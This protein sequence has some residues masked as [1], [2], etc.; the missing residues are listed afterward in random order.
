MSTPKSLNLF[1]TL[2]TLITEE[3]ST[4]KSH[5]THIN[6]SRIFG[7][8]ARISSHSDQE[9]LIKKTVSAIYSKRPFIQSRKDILMKITRKARTYHFVAQ[10]FAKKVLHNVAKRLPI[11]SQWYTKHFPAVRL[12]HAMSPLE[13]GLNFSSEILVAIFVIVIAGL[14]IV[15]FNP[16]S[17]TYNHQ[18]KSLAANLLA[19]HTG[20]NSALAAKHNTVSTSIASSGGFISKA[21]ADDNS[22]GSVL[23]ATDVA[24]SEVSEDGIEDNGITKANPDSVQKLVS[25]QVQ[26]YETKPFDTVYT[27]AAQF[28]VTPKT[29]RE[30]NGLP[31]NALKAGWFIVVPPVDGIV[32]EVNNPDLSLDDIASKYRAD[33]DK[34]VSYNGLEGPDSEIA[35]GDYLVIPGGVLPEAPKP[36]AEPATGTTSKVAKGS[37]PS[38]PKANFKGSNKFARGQCTDYAAQHAKVYWRGNANMWATNARKA[39]ATVNMTPS[40]GAIIQTSESRYGHVGVIESVSGNQV[41]FGEWNYAGPY[42]YTRRTLSINDPKVKAIIHP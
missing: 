2:G 23:G 26:I 42:K 30:T 40:V 19:N 14:N 22:V 7:G 32:L 8:I 10:Y 28:K 29:I 20:L 38:I 31:N 24:E 21:F 1:M 13:Y 27:V 41:T 39:G 6:L 12:N 35:M 17:S 9:I 25:R 4:R 5:F 37:K 15:I 34:V 36:A 11:V 3:K 18:D 33:L 16:F